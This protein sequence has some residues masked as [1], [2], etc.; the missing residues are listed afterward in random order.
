MKNV[1][2]FFLGGW[3]TILKEMVVDRKADV[4]GTSV[5]AVGRRIIEELP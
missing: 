1:Q 5:G 3:N 4:L 2:N